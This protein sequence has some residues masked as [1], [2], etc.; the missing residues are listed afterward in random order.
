MRLLGSRFRAHFLVAASRPACR[1]THLAA[2]HYAMQS[3]TTIYRPIFL[4]FQ[5]DLPIC[6]SFRFRGL[7]NIGLRAFRAMLL[8]PDGLRRR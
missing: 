1:A 3:A 5:R 2:L 7:L 6:F 8:A 4:G